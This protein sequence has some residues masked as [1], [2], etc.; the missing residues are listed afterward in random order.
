MGYIN[1]TK[2]KWDINEAKIKW[3][4]WGREGLDEEVWRI[5]FVGAVQYRQTKVGDCLKPDKAGEALRGRGR[6]FCF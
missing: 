1:E 4:F 2:L 3:G 5:L 6:E